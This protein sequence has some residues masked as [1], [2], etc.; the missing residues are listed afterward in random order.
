M[1]VTRYA[2]FLSVFLSVAIPCTAPLL[3]VGCATRGYSELSAGKQADVKRIESYLNNLQSLQAGFAQNGFGGNQ[4]GDGHFTYIPGALRMDYE[5]PM[6]RLVVAHDEKLMLID[7]S[8]E[9]VTQLS[10]KKNPLGY[11]LRRPISFSKEVQVTDVRYGSEYIQL[12]LAQ[13]DNPSQGLL[14]LQFSDIQGKLT[15]VGLKGVDAQRHRFG[16]AFFEVKEN[17]PVSKEIFTFPAH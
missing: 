16:L 15:L 2:K 6:G 8:S 9:S 11:L 7:R 4:Q 3:L 10:L 12:S 14:T 17:L 5:I 13:A 1:R